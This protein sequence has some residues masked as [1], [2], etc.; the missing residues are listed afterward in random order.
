MEVPNITIRTKEKDSFHWR[1]G[2]TGVDDDE[3]LNLV[4]QIR[5]ATA[6]LEAEMG[7][8]NLLVPQSDPN[9]HQQDHEKL[10]K[11]IKELAIMERLDKKA[12]THVDIAV[13]ILTKPQTDRGCKIYQ[14][15]LHDVLRHGSPGWVMIC[16]VGLGK[17]RIASM[18]KEKRVSLLAHVKTRKDL[19]SSTSLDSL[20]MGHKIPSLDGT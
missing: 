9:E 1:E 5:E 19:L 11:T 20:A 17:Q 3:L 16:A 2:Y 6:S 15:F 18:T 8:R 7:K 10:Y 12:T 4:Q 13:G 14:E